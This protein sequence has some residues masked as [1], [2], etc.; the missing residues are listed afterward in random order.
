MEVIQLKREMSDVL[1]MLDLSDN[2]LKG[3]DL[4]VSVSGGFLFAFVV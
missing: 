4:A 2:C 3:E 1:E